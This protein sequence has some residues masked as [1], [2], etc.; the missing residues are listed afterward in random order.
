MGIKHMSLSSLVDFAQQ[1][2][3]GRVAEYSDFATLSA[4]VQGGSAGSLGLLHSSTDWIGIWVNNGSTRPLLLS[5]FRLW[6]SNG[7]AE[8]TSGADGDGDDIESFN[9]ANTPT[10]GAPGVATGGLITDGSGAII[11]PCLGIFN[12]AQITVAARAVAVTINSTAGA[13][14][15]AGMFSSA[16]SKAFFG[17]TY[18][19]SSSDYRHYAQ[20][21]S[22]PAI[23]PEAGGLSAYDIALANGDDIVCAMSWLASDRDS[24]YG[25]YWAGAWRGDEVGTSVQQRSNSG[26]SGVFTK[27]TDQEVGIHHA[28][29]GGGAYSVRW[30]EINLSYAEAF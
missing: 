16:R 25:A 26:N 28:S 7:G 17:G 4:A 22:A 27:A 9:G 5:S 2:G 1:G 29:A 19:S 18:Y 11:L 23:A 15:S 20:M 14:F 12:P 21:V 8:F 3:A 30:T 24:N 6:A 10:W 13:G